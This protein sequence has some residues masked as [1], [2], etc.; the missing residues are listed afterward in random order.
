[1]SFRSMLLVATG[2]YVAGVAEAHRALARAQEVDSLPGLSIGNIC[3]A[4]NHLIGGDLPRAIEAAHQGIQ[5]AEQSGDRIYA[6]I[7]YGY[8]GWAQ[9]RAGQFEA[10]AA[11]LAKGLALAQELG[12]VFILADYFAVA[13]AEIAFRSG[14][15]QE[16]ISLAE[17]AMGIAKAMR[18]IYTESLARRV[19]GQAL[20]ALS[21]AEGP[22]WDE[23]EVQLAESM[24]LLESEQISLEVAHTHVAWGTV[25]RDREDIAA[26]REHWEQAAAQWKASDM[27]WELEEVRALI[28]T[29]PEA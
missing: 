27:P 14:R 16:A 11:S 9:G 12:Q 24:R 20:A 7:G 18:G 26:A 29:L 19:W 10:A 25:C 13:Q 22:P 5:A 28:A 21:R 6:Y 1:V 15:V 17:Q 8:R 2:D 23:A 3:M 4:Y